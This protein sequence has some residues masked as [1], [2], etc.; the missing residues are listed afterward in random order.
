MDKEELLDSSTG[1][2][3]TLRIW[4]TVSIVAAALCFVVGLIFAVGSSGDEIGDAVAADLAVFAF[5]AILVVG[6]VWLLGHEVVLGVARLVLRRRLK[7]PG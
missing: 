7:A 4:N 3:W 5:G 2:R 1:L 6:V